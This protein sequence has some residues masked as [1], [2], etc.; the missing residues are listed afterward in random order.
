MRKRA[1]HDNLAG[2]GRATGGRRMKAHRLRVRIGRESIRVS[3][4]DGSADVHRLYR[5]GC[6]GRISRGVHAAAAL[7]RRRRGLPIGAPLQLDWAAKKSGRSAG[8]IA[9]RVTR[10]L[11]ARRLLDGREH[12]ESPR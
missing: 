3:V 5:A 6:R 12:L 1:G 9:R 8:V 11:A 7:L 4:V 10:A 2:R